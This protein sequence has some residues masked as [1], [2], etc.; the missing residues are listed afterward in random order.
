MAEC[1]GEWY[2][3]RRLLSNAPD[4]NIGKSKTRDV[5]NCRYDFFPRDAFLRFAAQYAFIRADCAFLAA[6]DMPVRCLPSGAGVGTTRDNG[7]FGGRPRRLVGPCKASIALLSRLRS[8]IS[9]ASIWSVGIRDK[10]NTRFRICHDAAE[11][12]VL[13]LT[14]NSLNPSGQVFFL[15]TTISRAHPVLFKQT[16]R[17]TEKACKSEGQS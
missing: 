9:K 14:T 6:T 13:F 17:L 2:W 10:S 11:L 8:S 4:A 15:T 1:R 5:G 3:R 12:T 16:V 7:F